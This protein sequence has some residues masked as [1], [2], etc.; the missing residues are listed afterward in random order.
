MGYIPVQTKMILFG[1]HAVF[2]EK[3]Q[4]EKP[5]EEKLVGDKFGAILEENLSLRDRIECFRAAV[6]N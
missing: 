1:V 2:G 5:C 4:N 6:S 3:K